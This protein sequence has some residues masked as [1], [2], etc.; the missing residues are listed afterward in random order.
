MHANYVMLDPLKRLLLSGHF[1]RCNK[2]SERMLF[3]PL[4]VWL[5][6]QIG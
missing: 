6:A 5:L 3:E 1:F 2:E 4:A